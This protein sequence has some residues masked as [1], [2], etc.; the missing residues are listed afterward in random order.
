MDMQVSRNGVP[1][2]PAAQPGTQAAQPQDTR[3]IANAANGKASG[4]ERAPA[5]LPGED[6]ATL[7]AAA[8]SATNL[9]SQVLSGEAAQPAKVNQIMTAMVNGTYRVDSDR[10]ASTLML[11]MLQGV[12]QG[13][14]GA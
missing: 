8:N 13:R 11:T 2:E 10:L 9:I 3:S 7:S 5:M 12:G 14:A 6:R 4:I 1:N